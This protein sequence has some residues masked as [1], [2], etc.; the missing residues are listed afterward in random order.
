MDEKTYNDT[1][2][3]I[4]ADAASKIEKYKA[5]NR[6]LKKE[7]FDLNAKFMLH[8]MTI[9][10]M[11]YEPESG[12]PFVK[13]MY[14]GIDRITELV[15]SKKLSP[16]GFMIF[17]GLCRF[18]E[19]DT[20]TL[21]DHRGDYLKKY[22]MANLLGVDKSNFNKQFGHLL[23][24]GLVQEVKKFN[25]VLYCISDLIAYNG[26]NRLNSEPSKK[27]KNSGILY[28]KNQKIVV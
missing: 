13:F 2:E 14:S 24:L 10:K 20:S 5:E 16:A 4:A 17:F 1:L 26:L 28:L 15:S 3:S 23:E 9:A 12:S 21:I 7:L 18:L 11:I 25:K 22:E 27:M 6:E 8:K 19:P